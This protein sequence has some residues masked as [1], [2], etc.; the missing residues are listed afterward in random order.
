M[1]LLENYAF[2][3]PKV[4]PIM[5]PIFQEHITATTQLKVNSTIHTTPLLFNK[6]KKKTMY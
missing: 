3:F 4:F 5:L 6:R 2:I 1:G